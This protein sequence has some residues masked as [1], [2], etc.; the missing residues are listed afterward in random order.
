[1]EIFRGNQKIY[2]KKQEEARMP[3]NREK[4][5]NHKKMHNKCEKPRK[6]AEN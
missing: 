6:C 3:K 2:I 4:K 5:R 1:M